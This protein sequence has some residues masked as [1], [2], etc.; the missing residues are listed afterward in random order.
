[1]ARLSRAELLQKAA[2]MVGNW[3]TDELDIPELGGSV[4]VRGISGADRQQIVN[5]AR[6]KKGPR[7][8]EIDDEQFRAGM[9]AASLIDDEGAPLLQY[10]DLAVLSQLPAGLVDRVMGTVNRLSGFGEKEE[11]ALGKPSASRAA[12]TDSAS[13]SPSASTGEASPGA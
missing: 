6:I 8:G 9:L 4:R 2:A 11:E 1:M 5:K 13:S 7:K 3:P 12:S 10:D